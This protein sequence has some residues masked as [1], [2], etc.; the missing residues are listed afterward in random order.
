MMSIMMKTKAEQLAILTVRV[1]EQLWG[2]LIEDVVEVA[3][4]VALSS[5]PGKPPHLLGFANRHGDVM[6][7]LDLRVMLGLGAST[8]DINTLF[9]VV[10]WQGKL[11]GLVVDDVLQ[12]DYFPSDA[13]SETR[14]AGQYIR[15]IIRYNEHLIQVLA[16]EPLVYEV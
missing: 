8:V 15:G 6:P 5:P 7:V 10:R 13:L 4:M 3:A 12:V 11:T 1:G 2:F 9:V 14:N 16:V